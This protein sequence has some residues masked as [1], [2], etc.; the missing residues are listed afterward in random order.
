M[1]S[2]RERKNTE[3]IAKIAGIAK[4]ENQQLVA[5]HSAPISNFGNTGDFGNFGN[6][7]NLSGIVPSNGALLSCPTRKEKFGGGAGIFPPRR[8]VHRKPLPAA[9]VCGR[10]HPAG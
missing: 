7:F 9:A 2:G 3:G 8:Q 5:Q 1:R 10:H 4:I 6:S